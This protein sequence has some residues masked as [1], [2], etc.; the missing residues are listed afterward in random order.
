M[1]GE[2]RAVP[3]PVDDKAAF[4]TELLTWLDANAYQMPESRDGPAHELI[5]G[6]K[7]RAFIREQGH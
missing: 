2:W 4:V 1:V 3:T 7:L 6:D 5:P